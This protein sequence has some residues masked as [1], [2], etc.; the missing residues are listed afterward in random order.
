MAATLALGMLDLVGLIALDLS[1]DSRS[2]CGSE[3][4]FGL[5]FAGSTVSEAFD[6]AAHAL[7]R[8]L[9]RTEGIGQRSDG[10]LETLEAVVERDRSWPESLQVADRLDGLGQF[11]ERFARAGQPFEGR[12]HCGQ[13]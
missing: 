7:S 11:V 3:V 2:G 1:P 6:D 8:A 9:Q 5:S 4:G 12:R 13:G 10:D